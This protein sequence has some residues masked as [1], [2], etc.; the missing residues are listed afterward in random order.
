MILDK[1]KSIFSYKIVKY[2]IVGVIS[3]LIHIGTASLY[4][5]YIDSSLFQSNIVGFLVAY[6]FS[7]IMQSKLVF[8]HEISLEKAIRYF[9]VQFGSLLTSIAISDMISDFNSY[10]NTI[11]VVAF[12]P[13]ITFIIH[14]FWTFRVNK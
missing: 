9:I 2:S 12:M 13:L 4:I 10:I 14:K 7:Y 3:T 1:I 8:E 6:I 11:L 5:Y